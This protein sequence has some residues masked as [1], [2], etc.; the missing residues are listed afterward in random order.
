V[1]GVLAAETEGGDLDRDADGL[2]RRHRVFGRQAPAKDAGGA[3]GVPGCEI[4]PAGRL[5]ED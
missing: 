5:E 2:A 1:K 4:A 3:F